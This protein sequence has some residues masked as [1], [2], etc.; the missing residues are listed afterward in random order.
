MVYVFLVQGGVQQFGQLSELDSLSVCISSLCHD[1]GHDGFTNAYHV[2]LITERAI[3]YSDQSVQEN[4]HAAESFAI[5]SSTDYNFLEDFSR[6]DL[7]TFRQRFIGIIL[8]TDMARH[9]SD[10][11][12]MKTI[13]EQKSIQNGEGRQQLIDFTSN[14]TEFDTKQQLLEFCVHAADVS[15]QT[16]P[17]DVAVEWTKLLFEEF[18]NQ[19]DIEREKNL[20]ISFLCDRETVQIPQSQPGFVSFIL[21]P[22]FAT[23]SEILPELKQLET[24]AL[25]NSDKWK[26]YEET[27]EF[28]SVYQRK[29]QKERTAVADAE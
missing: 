28:K 10:L 16:R 25:E 3:R 12:K 5:L 17:F 6:D 7:K 23:V 1:Y 22:L 2:N 9:T 20:P 13:V 24:N 21:S 27:P 18:F 19:G 8:A 4:Y 26:S 11:A 15:T 29:T 14:K